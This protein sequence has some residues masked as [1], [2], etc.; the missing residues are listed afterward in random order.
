MIKKIKKSIY[1]LIC[2]LCFLP[3]F[4]FAKQPNIYPGISYE[5]W[6]M[7][8]GI[9]PMGVLGVR[10]LADFNNWFYGGVGLYSSVAGEKGGYF[11]LALEGGVQHHLFSQ[12][13]WDVGARVG[14]GGGHSV[15]VGGGL[16]YEPYAGLQ[17]DFGKLYAE[18]YYSYIDFVD[19]QISSDQFGLMMGCAFNAI[20]FSAG[21][22]DSQNYIAALSKIYFFNNGVLNLA[23]QA[24]NAHMEMLGAEFG[25]FISK[26]F[27]LF[28]NFSGAFHGNENGYADELLGIGYQFPLFHSPYFS[29]SIKMAAGSGGGGNVNTGGGFLYNPLLGLE[30]RLHS[31]GV[32]IDGG[33]LDAPQ[34]DFAAKQASVLLKYYFSNHN[35]LHSDQ[36]AWRI[37]ILNQ[38]YFEPRS[39]DGTINPTMQLLDIDFD[40]YLLHYLYVTGQVAFAYKGQN[41]DGYTS[42]MFGLGAITQPILKTPI[43][44]FSEILGGT[45]GGGGLSIGGGALVEPIV[46]LQYQINSVFALQA[47]TGYLMAVS[48]GFHSQTLEIGI[49][50][51][52]TD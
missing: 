34:G 3:S 14:G 26:R 23:N 49:N 48:G 30:Y 12:F 40:Y 19:G 51:R 2:S 47:S 45:G 5:Q 33:Y 37:R 21:N 36:H 8:N 24:M 32:E 25:H 4:T 29:G 18:I 1:F 35:A 6:K 46:G 31:I 43:Q 27:F 11:A 38:T 42:G 50:Y 15:P 7:P 10:G 41:T 44:L 39:S 17:Y 22:H 9:K 13:K 16:F 28:F 20:S 52:L